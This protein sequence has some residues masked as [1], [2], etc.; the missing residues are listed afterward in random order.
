MV[1]KSF[2]TYVKKSIEII[3]YHQYITNIL[4]W[5]WQMIRQLMNAWR[6]KWMI[7]CSK[8][9]AR[10]ILMLIKLLPLRLWRPG[11]EAAISK[12][13][14]P[15]SWTEEVDATFDSV[16]TNS[17]AKQNRTFAEIR[18]TTTVHFEF[19]I[20]LSVSSL[21]HYQIHIWLNC[22]VYE[23]VCQ[24]LIFLFPLV[25]TCLLIQLDRILVLYVQYPTRKGRG[26]LNP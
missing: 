17:N 1:L 18:M 19:S 8:W 15:S 14:F 2:N 5:L 24:V 10:Y 16:K 13:A 23:R 12:H 3:I 20:S 9:V 11:I 21:W 4:S 7:E 25:D 6:K 22:A 26:K